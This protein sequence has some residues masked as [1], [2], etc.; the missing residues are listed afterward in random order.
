MPARGIV[1]L[2]NSPALFQLQK[3]CDLLCPV[4]FVHKAAQKVCALLLMMV[5][6][7]NKSVCFLVSC[8]TDCRE[9]PILIAGDKRERKNASLA[10]Y[11][12]FK[13]RDRRNALQFRTGI[14]KTRGTKHK[15]ICC[16]SGLF[17]DFSDE[18]IKDIK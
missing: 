8:L 18:N 17:T 13:S 3:E 10:Q 14:Q 2:G 12:V 11:M 7:A 16:I 5:L 1:V 15:Y 6:Y 4:Y 9:M